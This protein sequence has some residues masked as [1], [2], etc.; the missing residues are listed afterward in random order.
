MHTLTVLCKKKSL[1]AFITI[2]DKIYNPNSWKRNGTGSHLPRMTPVDEY[3][4][5][6]YDDVTNAPL[7][8]AR[9]ILDEHSDPYI[10]IIFFS[11]ASCEVSCYSLAE[12]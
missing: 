9:S 8:P 3:D 4:V 11:T 10:H 2:T 7:Q 1:V 5:R 6:G 12:Y